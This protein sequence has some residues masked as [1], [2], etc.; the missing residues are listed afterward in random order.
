MGIDTNGTRY[1]DRYVL[2]ARREQTQS[3]TLWDGRDEVSG[4]ELAIEVIAP[5]CARRTGTW[6]RLQREHAISRR[7]A[8][9]NVLAVHEPQRAENITLLPMQYAANGDARSLQAAPYDQVLPVLI[10]VAEALRRAH[11]MQI[12]HLALSLRNI[13][14]D[15][16]NCALVSGFEFESGTAEEFAAAVRKDLRDFAMLSAELLDGPVHAPRR[17]MPPRLRTLFDAAYDSSFAATPISFATIVNELELALHDTAPLE[18]DDVDFNSAVTKGQVHATRAVSAEALY[19][20]PSIV[21]EQPNADAIAEI[22]EGVGGVAVD[23]QALALQPAPTVQ[24]LAAPALDRIASPPEPAAVEGL[25]RADRQISVRLRRVRRDVLVWRWLAISIAVAVLGAAYY[26]GAKNEEFVAAQARAS[27][28]LPQESVAAHSPAPK[29]AVVPT[30]VASTQAVRQSS[31]VIATAGPPQLAAGRPVLARVDKLLAAALGLQ[32][33]HTDALRG[34]RRVSVLDGVRALVDDARRA[35]VAR[36]F[37]RA[38]QGYSHALTLDRN[39]DVP[40]LGLS[41]VRRAVR[42]EPELSRL[43][44]AYVALGAGRLDSAQEAFRAL[45]QTNGDLPQVRD[46]LALADA[47]LLARQLAPRMRQAANLERAQRWAAAMQIYDS[48][49]AAYPEYI[50]AQQQRRRV[51]SRTVPPASAV[52]AEASAPMMNQ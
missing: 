12:A 20:A 40:R 23:W 10:D 7:L 45:A 25:R 22:L 28:T 31:A 44:E 26:L 16:G 17:A 47:A 8:H 32:S 39:H 36:N 21:D 18:I 3:G 51:A 13:R 27:R 11:S 35:E 42:G 41:R 4:E 52:N 19:G 6:A 14:L 1:F 2:L 5:H 49:L 24:P 9:S 30:K 33:T 50:P 15:A 34:M 38:A 43:V 48:V 29:S 37:T 46:G